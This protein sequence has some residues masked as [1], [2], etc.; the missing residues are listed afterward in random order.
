V[1]RALWAAKPAAASTAT[2]SSRWVSPTS[3][4][5]SAVVFDL[6]N[7]LIEWNRDLL[8]RKIIPDAERRAWFLEHVAN[9][10]WNVALDRGRSFDE[11]V[12]E[13]SV[14]H[15]DWADEIAAFRDRWVETMGDVDEDA[16]QLLAELLAADVPTYALTNWS[17]ETFPHAEARFEW[18]TWFDGIIVSGQE[19]VAKPEA[20]IFEL[21]STRYHLDL[22]CTL[23]TDD[24]ATN[25]EGARA[26]GLQAELWTSAADFRSHLVRYGVLNSNRQQ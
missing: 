22:A 14:E 25:I 17:A 10:A 24:M 3:G 5:V 21:L 26:A 8:Y 7:V 6:G 12:A 9:M 4:R 19:G 2:T 20:A 11:A 16:V 13:L 15:P 23:F 1:K 18:L